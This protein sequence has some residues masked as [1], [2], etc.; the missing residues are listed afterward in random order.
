MCGRLNESFTD[1]GNCGR[2]SCL[3]GNL[4][5][6][7][8]HVDF[9]MALEQAGGIFKQVNGQVLLELRRGLTWRQ[10]VVSHPVQVPIKGMGVDETVR[11]KK[12]KKG[13]SNSEKHQHLPTGLKKLKLERIL[14]RGQGWIVLDR[15]NGRTSDKE[16]I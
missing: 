8:W 6:H 10:T 1:S 9:E 5:V 7:F 11:M 13:L 4:K 3:G 16:Y 2:G 12:K 15:S 14:R